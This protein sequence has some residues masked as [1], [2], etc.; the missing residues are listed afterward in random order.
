V[1]CI[2][3]S[4]R[5][6][7]ERRI[8]KPHPFR[9]TRIAYHTTDH[10]LLENSKSTSGSNATLSSGIFLEIGAGASLP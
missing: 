10:D 1:D 5:K 3:K 6:T 9:I 7:E 4:I 2:A 8:L